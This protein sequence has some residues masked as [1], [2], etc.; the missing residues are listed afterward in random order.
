MS[1]INMGETSTDNR[2][3]DTMFT[4]SPSVNFPASNHSG[5]G[6]GSERMSEETRQVT[7]IPSP[8]FDHSSFP[9]SG[10]PFSCWTH[11]IPQ[12]AP[13]TVVLEL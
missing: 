6:F 4:G 2:E 12:D 11:I 10:F 1:Q 5:F 3:R 8:N 7:H 9:A 13:N